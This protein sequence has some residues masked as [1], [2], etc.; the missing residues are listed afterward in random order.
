[1]RQRSMATLAALLVLA[2]G[3][4]ISPPARASTE[5]C[6]QCKHVDCIKG[7]IKQKQAMA[8]GYDALA[9]TWDPLV[10]VEGAPADVVNFETIV[11]PAERTSFYR[12]L[13]DNLDT[14]ARQENELA[15]QVGL[16]AGC[17]AFAAEA[18]TNTY[19]TCTVDEK[20]VE[21]SQAQAPCRQIGELLAKHENLHRDR[22][23]ARKRT[24]GSHMW[25]PVDHPYSRPAIMQTPAGHAREEAAAYR[26]EIAALE[27]LRPK[28]QAKCELSFTGVTT[29]CTV[30]IPRAGTME[31]GQDISGK[32]CGDPLTATWTI[33]TVSWVRAPYIGLQRN[34]DPPWRSDCVAKGSPDEARR[35]QILSTG[36]AAGWMCVYDDSTPPKIIIRSFRLKQCVPQTEQTFIKTAT[37]SECEDSKPGP[38]PP[39]PTTDVPVS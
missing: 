31:M 34:V 30:P 19:A 23:I 25:Q 27:K 20:S 13:L 21:R 6:I 26:M 37:R 7:L 24:P 17:G 38:P 36:P 11:D 29:S 12:D 8:A 1:M 2:C 28:A 14:I 33:N 35:A 16:A 32:V 15:S 3:W 18:A 10:K 5:D 4:A 39:Q 9:H 22:C